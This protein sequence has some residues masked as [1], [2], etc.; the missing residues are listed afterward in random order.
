MSAENLFR[1]AVY[2]ILKQNGRAF[3]GPSCVYLDPE[4]KRCAVGW[5]LTEEEAKATVGLESMDVEQ[6]FTRFPAV[7]ERLLEQTGMSR[8]DGMRFLSRMQQLHDRTDYSKG[9]EFDFDFFRMK[10]VGFA[11]AMGFST[12][13]LTTEGS[14]PFIDNEHLA[15]IKELRKCERTYNWK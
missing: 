5:L 4:G 13:W 9:L 12:T 11:Q 1:K 8:E 14:W 2:N 7:G 6:L 3:Y 15:P 10:A